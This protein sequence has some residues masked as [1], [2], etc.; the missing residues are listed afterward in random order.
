MNI[1]KILV[2]NRGEIARRII[3]TCNKMGIETVA[4][5]S[6]A[7]ANMPHVLD[8]DEAVCIGPSPVSQSYLR[9]EQ[10]LRVAHQTNADAIH[11]GYGF[12]SENAEFASACEREGVTFIGPSSSVIR[13]MGSK[14]QARQLMQRAEVPVVPGSN[15]AISIEDALVLAEDI[16][17]PVI[18]KASAGGGGIGMTVA[19]TP[20]ELLHSFT[21]V[22]DRAQRFFGDDAVFLEKYIANPRHIEVQI[23]GDH[24]GNVIHLYERECSVQRRHQKVIEEAPAS[25]LDDE[26]RQVLLSTAVRGS[27]A[28]GYQNLGTME[29]VVADTGDF[30]FLEMNTRLQVEHSVTESILNLDLV[31]WQIRIA[32]G[33][34]LPNS[35]AEIQPVGHALECRIYAEDPVRFIPSPGEIQHLRWPE[36][37]R[38]ETGVREGTIVSHFYD[39]LVAKFITWS[40]D[41]K[42][43]INQMTQALGET[44]IDGIKTNI[45]LLANVLQNSNFQNGTYST[46]LISSIKTL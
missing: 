33:E 38:I 32:Q 39:P 24:F 34:M 42:E 8:A 44:T 1:R 10:I 2:A 28:I 21:S 25:S 40:T 26:E 29:F 11:T 18:V 30:Y 4:V 35:Q 16:G 15:E 20:V 43:A 14:I 6:E 27:K 13:A 45:P 9:G 37:I 7:D 17:Y 41:R 31:E 5:F 12:L 22:Q 19:R 23:A 46:S 36:G 3:R